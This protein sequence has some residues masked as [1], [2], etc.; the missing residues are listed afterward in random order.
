MT[1]DDDKFFYLIVALA[2]K[3]AAVGEEPRATLQSPLT[4]T[5]TLVTIVLLV[6]GYSLMLTVAEI[7]VGAAAGAAAGVCILNLLW[8]EEERKRPIAVVVTAVAGGVAGAAAA[9]LR[10]MVGS[11]SLTGSAIAGAIA[12]AAIVAIA[13]KLLQ[14]VINSTQG[15]VDY[16]MP[17]VEIIQE[18]GLLKLAKMTIKWVTDKIKWAIATVKPV[19]QWIIEATKS[20][21]NKL[22]SMRGVGLAAVAAVGALGLAGTASVLAAVG[23][24]VAGLVSGL[25]GGLLGLTLVLIVGTAIFG[26]DWR[27]HGRDVVSPIA[28]FLLFVLICFLVTS[29]GVFRFCCLLL[30]LSLFLWFLL[31]YRSEGN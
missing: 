8:E 17:F 14:W 20:L 12:G 30:F 15:L 31:H 1:F 25:F 21:F 27:G 16:V 24:S 9:K 11:Y 19:I 13:R 10:S 3:E 28:V 29:L 7:V 5:L 18:G 6:L 4:L 22:A 23:A 26:S 2:G